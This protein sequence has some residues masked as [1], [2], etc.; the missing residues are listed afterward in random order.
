MLE[1]SNILML[2]VPGLDTY[3]MVFEFRDIGSQDADE[4]TKTTTS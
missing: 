2:G 3:Y 4:A 1:T